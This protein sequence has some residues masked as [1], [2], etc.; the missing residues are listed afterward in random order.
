MFA[1]YPRPMLFEGRSSRG[2][3]PGLHREVPAR[4]ERCDHLSHVLVVGVAV[5]DKENA[6][7]NGGRELR[8]ET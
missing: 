8:A 5:A 4:R 7:G 3:L 2:R 6:F 1:F